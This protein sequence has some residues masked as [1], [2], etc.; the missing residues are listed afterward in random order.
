MRLTPAFVIACV[1]QWCFAQQLIGVLPVFQVGVRPHNFLS[2][3]GGVSGRWPEGRCD[4]ARPRLDGTLPNVIRGGDMAGDNTRWV[5]RWFDEVWNQA[6]ENA[7][8]AAIDQMMAHDAVMHGLGEAG[9]DTVGTQ[10]FKQF[11][12]RFRSA[13]SDIH[14]HIDATVEQP[15]MIATRWTATCSSGC[16]RSARPIGARP[17]TTSATSSRC[18]KAT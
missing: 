5:H 17:P 13:F 4:A 15:D 6:D 14:I 1:R 8:G 11:N 10:P 7:V 2:S 16:S 12:A 3:S 9:R 18:P